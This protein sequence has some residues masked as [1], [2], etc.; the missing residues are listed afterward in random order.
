MR[1]EAKLSNIGDRNAASEVL[2]QEKLSLHYIASVNEHDTML[3]LLLVLLL[4]LDSF[5]RSTDSDFT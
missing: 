4:L 5:N 2:E 3:V 1:F